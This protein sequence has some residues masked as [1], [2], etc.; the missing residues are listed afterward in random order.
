L[1]FDCQSKIVETLT[2][3][4]CLLR[5]FKTGMCIHLLKSHH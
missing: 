1:K 2:R 4:P 3:T 5:L